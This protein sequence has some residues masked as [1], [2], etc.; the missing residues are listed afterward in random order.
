VR[1]EGESKRF[2]VLLMPRLETMLP[3]DSCLLLCFYSMSA[4]LALQTT[5]LARLFLFVC[6]SV[7]FQYYVQ[8]NE[9][10]IVQFSASGRTILLVSEEVKSLSGY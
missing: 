1:Y 8:T 3:N 9:D 4:L 10:T 7:T 5:V 6:H 2:F